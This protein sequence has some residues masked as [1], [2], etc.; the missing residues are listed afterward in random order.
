MQIPAGTR[1]SLLLKFK[2]KKKKDESKGANDAGPPFAFLSV[3]G[4]VFIF[5]IVY[6]G[7]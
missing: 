6:N 7:L 4:V 2:K 3:R 5:L 1:F